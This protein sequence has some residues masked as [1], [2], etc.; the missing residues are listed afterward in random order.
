MGSGDLNSVPP[1]LKVTLH[2]PRHLPTPRKV[3]FK[4]TNFHVVHMYVFMYV[5]IIHHHHCTCICLLIYS[6]EKMISENVKLEFIA[7]S[8]H[9]PPVGA[10]KCIAESCHDLEQDCEI[11]AILWY[12]SVFSQVLTLPSSRPIHLSIGYLHV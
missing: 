1:S 10:R 11:D 6:F 8:K 4:G 12:H 2:Q 5:C 7:K 3:C 9:Y